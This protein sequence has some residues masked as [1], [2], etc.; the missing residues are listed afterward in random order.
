MVSSL[1]QLDALLSPAGQ[2]LLARL[3]DVELPPAEVL[4]LGDELRRAHPAEVVAAAFTLHALRR[5]ARAKFARADEMVFTRAGLEQASAEHV[6]RHRAVRFRGSRRLADLCTGI[7]GDL[8]ALAAQAPTLA[9]DRAPLHLR[10]AAINAGVYGRGAAVTAWLGDV[11]AAPLAGVDAAFVDPARRD[12]AGRSGPFRSEP[13]LDWCFDLADSVPAVGIK[14]APGLDLDRVPRGWEIEFVADD[15][16]L[17]E[18]VLWSPALATVP[19]RATILPAGEALLPVPGDPVPIAPPGTFLLDPNPAVT[20]AG[21]VE[22]LARTLGAWKIDDRIAFLCTDHPATTPFARTL[23]IVASLP[24]HPKRI[25]ARLR[26]LEIGAVDI[27]RRGLAG[28]VA[29]IRRRLGLR[30]GGRATLVMTRVED[31][32]W[33]FVCAD[34]PETHPVAATGTFV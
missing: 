4:R 26:E 11:R 22:D 34:V 14:A 12:V 10:M 19:R 24:W 27:R 21:L 8:I 17:K 33:C 32:P 28:D 20:R 6:A 9:V 5:R 23:R 30:G 13:P 1:D 7:G 25:A 2:A 3:P 31:R 15:R 16:E 29:A 18:A